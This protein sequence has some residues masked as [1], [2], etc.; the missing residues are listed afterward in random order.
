MWLLMAPQVVVATV[1][2]GGLDEAA[3]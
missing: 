2:G 1:V 3:I